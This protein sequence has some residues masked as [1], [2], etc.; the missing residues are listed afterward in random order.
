[1]WQQ[2]SFLQL[3]PR[4]A[5]L[6]VLSERPKRNFRDAWEEQKQHD[7]IG[8]IEQQFQEAENSH[9]RAQ[10]DRNQTQD[11]NRNQSKPAK[12]KT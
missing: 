3:F 7:N 10:D 4:T 12:I 8:S 1:M 11:A 9:S 2:L 5:K 6:H